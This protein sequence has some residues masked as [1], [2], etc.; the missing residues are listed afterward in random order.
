MWR[1]RGTYTVKD[2]QMRADECGREQSRREEMQR[3]R[4]GG[5]EGGREEG[6]EGRIDRE[7]GNDSPKTPNAGRRARPD[8]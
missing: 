8:H 7:L 1:R 3:P 6:R 2:E 4:E 5:R